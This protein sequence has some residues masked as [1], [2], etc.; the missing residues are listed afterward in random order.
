[1]IPIR[2][3]AF[4]EII[5]RHPRTVRRWLADDKIRNVRRY[6]KGGG[7]LRSAGHRGQSILQAPAAVQALL[8][9]RRAILEE[10]ERL[11]AQGLTDANPHWREGKYLYLIHPTQPDGSRRREYVGNDPERVGPALAPWNRSSAKSTP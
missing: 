2:N 5:G 6:H 3:F 9:K 7:A 4:R 10:M 11:E 1:M 8:E